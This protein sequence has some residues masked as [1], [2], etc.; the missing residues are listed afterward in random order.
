MRTNAAIDLYEE[1]KESVEEMFS[2][3]DQFDSAQDLLD[4]VDMQTLAYHRNAQC[5]V[6]ISLSTIHK[7]KGLEYPHVF[8]VTCVDGII[9]HVDSKNREEERRILYVAM[10]RAIDSLELSAVT[11]RKDNIVYVSPFLQDVK[12][13]LKVENASNLPMNNI[14]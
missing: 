3:G 5:D 13:L 8:I 12:D 11:M 10:T 2:L 7:S 6:A 4:Y 9:P 14:F 1:R